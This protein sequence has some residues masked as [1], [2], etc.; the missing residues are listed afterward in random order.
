MR[1]GD[2]PVSAVLTLYH[3]DRVMPYWG[4]GISDARRLRS[5]ELMYYRLMRH[6]SAR[7]KTLFDFGRSK[8]GSGQAA[9][10]KSF[11]FEPRPLTYYDWSA[12][13]VV[14]DVSPSS[15]KY[16]RRIDLWKK[17][18]LPVANMLGPMISRG[19]G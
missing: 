16:Q 10:K 4:G 12:G 9:W 7:A 17:L 14:R 1:E 13:G 19:L 5:N 18:P 6:G 3:G 2:R 11:G 8:V 15:A